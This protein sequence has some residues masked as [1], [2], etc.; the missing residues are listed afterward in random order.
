M[1]LI[2]AENK[3]S[4]YEFDFG[5]NHS[6]KNSNV[7]KK[8]MTKD[9]LRNKYDSAWCEYIQ[10]QN[11]EGYFDDTLYLLYIVMFRTA[12]HKIEMYD[13]PKYRQNRQIK[14]SSSSKCENEDIDE[15]S[16][17]FDSVVAANTINNAIKYLDD[18]DIAYIEHR[19]EDYPIIVTENEEMIGVSNGESPIFFSHSKYLPKWFEDCLVFEDDD[20]LTYD[21]LIYDRGFSTMTMRIKSREMDIEKNY[22]DDLPYEQIVDFLNSED[23]GLVILNGDAGTGKTSLI[24]HFIKEIDKDFL[25]LDQSSFDNI[26]DGSLMQTLSDY[27]NAVL[28]LEDCEAM[29]ANRI[30]GNNSK[31]AALLNLTDGL[32]GDSFKF[33]VICT[34]NAPIGQVDKALLRKGR[35]RVRYEFKPLKTEKV[36]A[37]A[38]S[39]GIKDIPNKP[40]TLADIYN[41]ADEVDFK[42]EKSF[43]FV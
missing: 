11:L 14:A 36:K 18:N 37:L 5:C 42:E 10:T 27:E 9:E 35:L 34:F 43:G 4:N 26:T 39:L 40:M 2:A 17:K 8:S 21:Y 12:P 19:Y 23:C 6:Y 16:E 1:V 25:Y 28:I 7:L 32:I 41:Y 15:S 29:L 33:K 22:N 20:E 24:R 30:D 31:M 3:F 38:E 13:Y